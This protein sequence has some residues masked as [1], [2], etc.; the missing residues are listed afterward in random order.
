MIQLQVNPEVK[1]V[2][3]K[4]RPVPYHLVEKTKQP[5]QEFQEMDIIEDHPKNESITWCSPMRV[6]LK[7]SNKDEIRIWVDA[8]RPNKAIYRMQNIQTP[9][10]EDYTV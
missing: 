7:Q 3:C 9:V 10:V 1:P 8:R 2:A 5:L 6:G 4:P